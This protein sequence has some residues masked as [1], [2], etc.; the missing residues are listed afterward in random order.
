MTDAQHKRL[1][2]YFRKLADQLGLR[3]WD[4]EL[5]QEWNDREGAG[6]SVQCV[7]GRKFA[8]IWVCD[9]FF[10][11]DPEDQ[12]ATCVHEL[13]HCHLDA[14]R[15]PFVNAKPQLMPAVYDTLYECHRDA[16]EYATDGIAV[17]VARLL[18]LP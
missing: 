6:A 18:P 17:A 4:I 9:E 8:R 16:L 2:R 11:S 12:R 7:Y 1:Q 13:M 3:D 10:T 14:M 15:L 5:Q